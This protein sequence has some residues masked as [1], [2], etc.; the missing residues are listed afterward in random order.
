MTPAAAPQPLR[1]IKVLDFTHYLAGPTC[2]RILA[3]LGAEVI[4]IEPIAGE[5]GR[6]V[7]QVNGYGAMFGFTC[8]GKKSVCVDLKA[9]EGLALATELVA[10]VDVAVENFAP[11][12]MERLGL[13][14]DRLHEINP[15]LIVASV[16]G[17]GQFGP[18][19]RHTSFDIIGQAMSGVM[20]MTGDPDGP[21][22][23]V[24]NYIGDPNTGI[25]AALGVCAALFERAQTGRGQHI[26]VS[27]VEALLYLDMCNVAKYSLSEGKETPTRFGAHHYAVAP[28]GVFKARRGYIVIQAMEH[29]FPNL[30][31]A[32]GQPEL[33]QDTRFADN[34]ARLAHAAA[35]ARVIEAW[36]QSFDDDETP[37]ARLAE[38]RIP[39]APVLNVGQ[40]LDHPHIRARG[41]VKQVQHPTFG[42]MEIT[43]TPFFMSGRPT[44][45]QGPAPLL[46]EHNRD[47]LMELL[48]Y[49][50]ERI[51]RLT[52]DGV[53]AEEPAVGE[54][55]ARQSP[56]PS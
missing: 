48:G 27:Q 2:T 9:P 29:Q 47:V 42:P 30:A 35:L 38:A 20:D 36:L 34:P 28:L 14:F 10:K 11:G 31:K 21:P 7:L 3:D 26:D 4:K 18:L 39:S 37:L 13:G 25:H 53:L 23:Y 16:S 1:G 45:A 33:L 5:S 24:G 43:N 52:A 32:M 54:I 50:T 15:A 41:M 56:H 8:A 12:T 46:G 17:F 49:S 40:A 19:S 6:H 51:E 44:E 55:R 22:Q